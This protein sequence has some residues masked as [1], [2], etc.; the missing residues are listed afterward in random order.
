MLSPFSS[1]LSPELLTQ[2]TEEESLRVVCTFLLIPNCWGW[3]WLHC[4]FA[5]SWHLSHWRPITKALPLSLKDQIRRCHC[6]TGPPSGLCSWWNLVGESCAW[7]HSETSHSPLQVSAGDRVSRLI[8]EQSA[9]R[10]IAAHIPPALRAEALEKG[11]T[12]AWRRWTLIHRPRRKG[13][14]GTPPQRQPLCLSL[15]DLPM[16]THFNLIPNPVLSTQ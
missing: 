13:V 6:S 5:E 15:P 3:V 14:G 2:K 8:P 7:D 11:P 16:M 9:T 12:P 10:R 4:G 1:C